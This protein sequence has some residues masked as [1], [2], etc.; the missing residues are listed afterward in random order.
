M[1]VTK[2]LTETAATAD[3]VKELLTKSKHLMSGDLHA[4]LLEAVQQVTAAGRAAPLVCAKASFRSVSK[5]LW[6]RSGGDRHQRHA[7]S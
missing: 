4:A 1:E 2:R 3:S 5:P 7:H 6:C